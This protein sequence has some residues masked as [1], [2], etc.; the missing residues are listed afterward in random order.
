MT[1]SVLA[2]NAWAA[3]G[4]SLTNTFACPLFISATS[5][6]NTNSI[7][8]QFQFQWT[9]VTAGTATPASDEATCCA[10]TKQRTIAAPIDAPS[11][12]FTWH[13]LNPAQGDKPGK[14]PASLFD[15]IEAVCPDFVSSGEISTSNCDTKLTSGNCF[16]ATALRNAPTDEQAVSR[17]RLNDR[18]N[19][20]LALK[21]ET[22][23]RVDS[24]LI[25]D[26]AAILRSLQGWEKSSLAGPYS[27][28]TTIS[29]ALAAHGCTRVEYATL[30]LEDG[31]RTA[32]MLYDCKAGYVVAREALYSGGKAVKAADGATPF[33]L[34]SGFEVVPQYIEN[35]AGQRKSTLSWV[36]S[37][38]VLSVSL[39]HAG[40]NEADWLSALVSS[41]KVSDA[42]S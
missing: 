12:I 37:P 4:V 7:P 20:A 6:S 34:D 32:S 2:G 16:I 3:A 25:P 19:V 27:P 29:D 11:S 14:G 5:V 39:Y 36:G 23:L 31:S 15:E 28:L 8:F 17:E 42:K 21:P 22:P 13:F 1:L 40:Q 9:I 33:K 41:V 10:F 18:Q 30:L 24:D 35:G 38:I 26:R